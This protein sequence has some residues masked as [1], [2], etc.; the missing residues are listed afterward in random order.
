[1]DLVYE[2]G[3]RESGED[4]FLSFCRWLWQLMG[5]CIYE[6]YAWMNDWES[7]MKAGYVDRWM[8]GGIYGSGFWVF[9]V[10]DDGDGDVDI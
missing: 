5:F 7:G 10:G 9:F 2:D 8:G 3:R 1:M 4:V 6:G